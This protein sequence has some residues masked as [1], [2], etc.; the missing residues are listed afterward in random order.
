M[1]KIKMI[2]TDIDGTLVDDAKNLSPK[3]IEVLK[4]ARANGIYVVL[5]TGR[6]L[7]GVANLLTQLGLDNDDNFV[8][9]HNGAQAVSAKS[10]KAIFKHL[11]D[12]SDFKRLDAISKELKVN[13]QTITT[14]SQLFVTSPDINYYSVLDTFYT[15]MQ[16]RYRPVTEVPEDIE[17]AKI[18]WADYPEKI[19]NALPNL[20]KDLLDKFDC[21]RSEK[22][23]FEFMNPLATKGNAAIELGKHLGIDASEILTAGDQN[24]DLSMIEKGGFSIAMG[25]AI[26]TIKE[27]A[28]YITD[29]NNNDGLAKAIEKFVFED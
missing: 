17:I 1:S 29:T 5:C 9:T 18:M 7:S 25:N 20:P 23:F 11:L 4:K 13:M 2:A 22:W 19:D 24:N 10:G 26:D 15:H 21:I 12:F 14:D 27:K 16:L 3:T 8:I 28:D 6:P